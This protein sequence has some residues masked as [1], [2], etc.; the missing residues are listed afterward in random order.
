MGI[1]ARKSINLGGG[2]RLNFSKTGV[3][4]STGAGAVPS[5]RP[6]AGSQ[7]DHRPEWHPRGFGPNTFGRALAPLPRRVLALPQ[8]RSPGSL[9]R[10][11]K[12]SSTQHRAYTLAVPRPIARFCSV[13]KPDKVDRVE[14]IDFVVGPRE[15]RSLRCVVAIGRR[16]PGRFDLSTAERGQRGG[17]L[18]RE[19]CFPVVETNR[20][21]DQ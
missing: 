20:C 6:L 15:A 5:F 9:P 3:G 13:G 12:S 21:R 11:A 18:V 7:D 8:R 19:R 17:R 1:R 14:R 2:V 16:R 10:R 4:M